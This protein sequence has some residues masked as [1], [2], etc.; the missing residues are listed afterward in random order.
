MMLMIEERDADQQHRAHHH[1]HVVHLQPAGEVLTEP[2]PGKHSLDQH[3]AVKQS[4]EGQRHDG[5]QLHADI[6]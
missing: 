5:Q 2:G 1:V 4:A 3:R 6:A